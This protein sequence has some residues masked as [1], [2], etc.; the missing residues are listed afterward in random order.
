MGGGR[1]S[2]QGARRRVTYRRQTA[3][4]TSFTPTKERC[5]RS[6]S[7]WIASKLAERRL[8]F[9]ALSPILDDVAY[10]T[11]TGNAQLDVSRG[12]TLVYRK[13]SVATPAMSTIQWRAPG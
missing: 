5:L 7:T 4:V 10:Q 8:L 13:G 3:P 11:V 2:S 6:R 1:R 12:G 9:C